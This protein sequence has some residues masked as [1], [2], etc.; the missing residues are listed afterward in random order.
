MYNKK[1]SLLVVLFSATILVGAGCKNNTDFN[2]S[3]V[4]SIQ[5]SDCKKYYDGCN[6]CEKMGMD[7]VCTEKY[8]SELD[9][10]KCLDETQNANK[11]Y[12]SAKYGFQY[13]QGYVVEE[14][15]ELPLVLIVRGSKGRVEIFK[16]ADF[17]DP[18]TKKEGVRSHGY[19]SSGLDEYEAELVPKEKLDIGGHGV[20][21][22]YRKDDTQTREE[23]R[24]IFA[25]LQVK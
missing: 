24:K 19:S 21:L 15:K 5:D 22:F 23:V 16:N 13:P 12:T 17:K 25:S 11:A 2:N 14:S 7:E 18:I 20:W 4:Q 6:T 10:P 1:I 8:C 3:L 9:E